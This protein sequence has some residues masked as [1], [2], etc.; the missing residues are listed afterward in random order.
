MCAGLSDQLGGPVAFDPDSLDAIRERRT[1]D[2][3]LV[4]PQYRAEPASRP[5]GHSGYTRDPAFQEQVGL[6]ARASR[7]AIDGSTTGR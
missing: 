3:L 7:R 5:Y 2:Y 1:S 4:N 6:L